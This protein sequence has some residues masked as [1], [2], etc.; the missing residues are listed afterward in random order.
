MG[1]SI[2]DKLGY[3]ATSNELQTA[4]HNGIAYG[5]DWDGTINGESS[6]K[7]LGKITTKDVHFHILEGNFEKGDVR[8]SLYEAPT[9]TAN[10]TLIT[11]VTNLNRNFVDSS[12]VSMYLAPT[13]TGNGTKIGGSYV[14]ISGLGSGVQSSRVGVAGGRV[15]KKNTNYLIVIENIDTSAVTAGISF[16]WDEHIISAV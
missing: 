2:S 6:I 10:G 9:I 3:L 12:T 14:P 8:V 15:L 7:F 4:I 11:S 13:T 16:V 1:T 5:T